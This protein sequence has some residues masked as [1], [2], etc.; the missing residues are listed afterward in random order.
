MSGRVRPYRS[1]R[2]TPAPENQIRH[3]ERSGGLHELSLIAG[4]RRGFYHLFTQ[5]NLLTPICAPVLP[6]KCRAALDLV[7]LDPWAVCA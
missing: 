3:Y 1:V 2:C 7:V 5:Q 6:G 4:Q